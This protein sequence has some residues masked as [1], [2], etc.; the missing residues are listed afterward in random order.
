MEKEL[1]FGDMILPCTINEYGRVFNLRTNR[2]QAQFNN[3]GKSKVYKRV[4]V[5][6]EGKMYREYVHILVAKHFIGP[7]P[8]PDMVVNHD[9]GN[10]FNNHVSNLYWSTKKENAEHYQKKL[11]GK[12]PK[13][14]NIN[15]REIYENGLG[16]KIKKG[17]QIH[18]IDWNNL[19]DELSNLI[20]VTPKEHNWLHRFE[21]KFL[22]TYSR[23]EIRKLLNKFKWEIIKDMV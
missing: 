20:E 21:N 4:R 16:V 6:F 3:K 9:D 23:E 8:G 10:T 14:K 2:E 5:I 13:A 1:R 19:N 22:Q 15:H 11:K 12:R 17:N 18:H 7:P